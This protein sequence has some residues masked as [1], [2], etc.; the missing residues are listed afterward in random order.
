[1]N[2]DNAKDYLP[3][4]KALAEGK[5]I[6]YHTESLGWC[7]CH[8]AMN[9]LFENETH[10]FRVKPEPEPEHGFGVG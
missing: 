8:A 4:V 3:L 6:Q 9:I 7:D 2:K 10:K 5:T 1:M